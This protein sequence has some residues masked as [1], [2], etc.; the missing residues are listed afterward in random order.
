MTWTPTGEGKFDSND[1]EGWTLLP[2]GHV[3]TVDCYV[4]FTPYPADPTN[5]EKYNPKTGKWVTAGS[6][7]KTLTDPNLFEMGPAV[8]RPN[9]T[10]VA[11]GDNGNVSI[12]HVHTGKW[13]LGHKLLKKK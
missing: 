12:Y 13:S 3:L 6:T 5:S 7:I 1:E 4:G 10:V 9:G 2:S 11:F 8:L